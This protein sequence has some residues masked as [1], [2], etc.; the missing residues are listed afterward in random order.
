[1][2]LYVKEYCFPY[3]QL[4]PVEYKKKMMV[5]GIR[6]GWHVI[7]IRIARLRQKNVSIIR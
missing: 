4:M 7:L 6:L 1:M 3:Y 5:N 2:F